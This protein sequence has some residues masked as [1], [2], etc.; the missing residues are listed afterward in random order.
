MN[1]CITGA[2]GKLGSSLVDICNANDWNVLPH[3]GRQI[4]DLSNEEH[5]VEFAA[6]LPELDSLICCAGGKELDG[7][8][9]SFQKMMND[10]LFVTYL[11][12]KHLAPKLRKLSTILTIGSVDG[13]FG[14]AEGSFYASAK[15]ALHIYSRCLAKQL[16]LNEI[17]V[18][19][20]ALGTLTSVNI[21]KISQ[22]IVGFCK[23]SAINGQVIRIDQSHHTF[24]C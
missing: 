9:S 11:C 17:T 15:A 16:M 7:D 1:I 6:S 8:F 2:N 13:C 5:V 22:S 20:L 19:C 14:Q 24:P 21:D 12:C 10:N 3:N 23:H 18:N 4:G